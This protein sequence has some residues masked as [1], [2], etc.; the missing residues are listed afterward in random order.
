VNPDEVV[1]VGAAIQG[2]V[3]AGDV[4]DVL[5]L[6]VTPLTLGIETAGGVRTAMI[7]RNSTI[8]TSK[9]QVFSTYAD[10]QPQVEIHV[11]QGERE[12]ANDNKS[13]GTFVLDGIAPAPRGVPQIEVTFNLD[14]NG[15][16]NVTAK[17]KATGKENS[18]TIQDSGN[19]SKEDI[20]KA[21]KEAEAH[22]DEDKKKREAVDAKNAL[23]NGIYQAEKMPKEFEGK[24]SDDD[25]KVI[26]E[27]V[28]EA[29]K[30]LESDDKD[31]LEKAANELLE[32]IQ[33]IGAKLY[34]AAAKEEAADEDKK[35]D[36]KDEPVE[37][38]VVE[39]DGKKGKK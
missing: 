35:S 4:K 10:N 12:M 13:L 33:G 3:L 26:D 38:E 7:D 19:M 29:K 14:A 11:L 32:K 28:A 23:E 39:D 8:P 27:A 5:L 15:I 31:E 34:E 37:G 24:I 20:E 30:H 25:K 9:S 36:D 18:V 6:D 1:A 2:G 16:L 21:Q 22:A 17:D